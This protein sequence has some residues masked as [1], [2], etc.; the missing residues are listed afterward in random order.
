MSKTVL[1]V[2]LRC[3]ADVEICI[4]LDLAVDVL[5]WGKTWAWLDG[6]AGF[7]QALRDAV[8]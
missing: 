1:S 2:L 5:K 8:G 4:R 6:I 3:V 7:V